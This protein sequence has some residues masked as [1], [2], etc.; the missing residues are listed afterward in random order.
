MIRPVLLLVA[1]APVP[2]QAKTRL[3]PA[4]GP[5]GAARLAAA[6][7]L[8]TLDAAGAV[9]ADAEV[10]VALA[11][12][13]R[14]AVEAPALSAALAGRTVVPQRGAG[15][16]ARLAHAHADAA[17]GRPC[18]QV[19]MDT[20]HLPVNVLNEALDDLAT[21]E[22]GRALLG[23]AFDGGWWA[24]GVTRGEDAACLRGVVMSSDRT[25]QDTAEALRRA[26]AT[27]RS[28][29]ALQDVDTVADVRDVAEQCEGRFAAVA[30]ELLGEAS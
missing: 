15:L 14:H 20:P 3:M 22:A 21:G 17:G 27:V 4:F 6:A 28:L 1:K 7:F 26:G 13:L 2:G 23:P 16:S 25:G 8:D 12:S 19:G 10:V 30:R 29:P 11:G 18:L 5:F 9:D 24:L